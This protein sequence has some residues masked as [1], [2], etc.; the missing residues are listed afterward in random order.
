MPKA[1]A[2]GYRTERKIRLMFEGHGWKV[3]RA[4]ASLGEADIVCIKQKSILFLQIKS[5]KKQ[6]LY[7]Y[8]YEKNFLEGFPYFLVIDFGQGNI[9]ILPPK[10]K[11]RNDEGTKLEEFLFKNQ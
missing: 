7:Y 10:H 2:K 3:V 9:R 11:I 4:G 8:G 5:T 6:S 1:K